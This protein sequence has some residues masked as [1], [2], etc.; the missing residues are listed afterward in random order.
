M[1]SS[2]EYVGL[3]TRSKEGPRHVTGRG[4]YTDDFTE[5]G[6]LQAVF[7]RSP[8]A[9]ARILG[10]DAEAA[11][12]RQ[13]VFAVVTPEDMKRDTKP[14]RPGRYAAG[15]KRARGGIRRSSGQGP[16]RG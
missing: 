15:L 2:N 14:F 12:S 3:A 7:I 13:D 11:K 4:Q 16:L 1:A 8:H 9:H 5:P 6:M 10:V